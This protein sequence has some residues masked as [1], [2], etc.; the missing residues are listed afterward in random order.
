MAFL[1]FEETVLE[2]RPILRPTGETFKLAGRNILYKAW[3]ARGKPLKTGWR[4]TRDELTRLCFSPLEPR[5]DVRL[6]IDFHPT[7]TGKI[8]LIEPVEI[9]AYT[10][11]E[12]GVAQWTP[13]MLDFRTFSTK[14]TNRD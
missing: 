10:W 5:P 8:G 12:S 9:Y 14:S 2:D 13:L 6:I 11:G 3:E 1:I 4:V 7:A